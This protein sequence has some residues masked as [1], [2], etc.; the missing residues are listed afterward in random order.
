MPRHSSFD[1]IVEKVEKWT[2]I[3]SLVVL[4][5]A[6]F[7]RSQLLKVKVNDSLKGKAS[8]TLNNL[9]KAYNSEA[10]S[11]DMYLNFAK[12]ASTEDHRDVA[13]LFKTLADAE[14]V[15]RDNHAQVIYALGATPVNN[16]NSTTSQAV[17]DI[18]QEVDSTTNNSI[19]FSSSN[20]SRLINLELRSSVNGESN[21]RQMYSK[22]IKQAK[23]DNN[24]A[25]LKTFQTALVA[26]NQHAQI[27]NQVI[28]NLDDWKLDNHEFYVCKL[29]GETFDS[30][31]ALGACSSESSTNFNQGY[32]G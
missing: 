9:Q 2:V 23:L 7:G 10:N 12:K 29:T 13:L 21:E 4:S 31:P 1:S 24:L 3:S 19:N 28:G 18:G 8:P 6:Y 20:S 27:L 30:H 25:A 16:S 14:K 11:R 5:L 17:S 22:F 32:K 26:E 15:H